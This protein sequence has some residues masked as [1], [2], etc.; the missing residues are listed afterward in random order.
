LCEQYTLILYFALHIFFNETC[1]KMTKTTS[2]IEKKEVIKNKAKQKIII[3]TTEKKTTQKKIVDNNLADTGMKTKKKNE[4]KIGEKADAIVKKVR[5]EVSTEKIE[6]KTVET[7]KITFQLNYQTTYGQELFVIGN[8]NL[9][10]D[11]EVQKALPLQF[12]NNE[13]WFAS[14][15]LPRDNNRIITYNYLLKNTDGTIQF[16]CGNDKQIDTEKLKE[17]EI[18]LIDAWNFTGYTQ[19]TFFTEPFKNILLKQPKSTVK[20]ASNKKITHIFSTKMPLLDSSETIAIIGSGKALGNWQNDKALPMQYDSSTGCYTISVDLSKEDFPIAYKY[21]LCNIESNS[22]LTFEQG[23]NRML[24]DVVQTNKLTKVSD[25][26]VNLPLKNWRGAG[27][28]I[29]VFGLKTNESCGIGEFSDLIAL[30]NWS[31]SVGLKLIQIL[32]INDTTANHTWED[33]Y[34]YAAISAFAL[35][36]IYT[37][38]TKATHPSNKYLL[39]KLENKRIELNAKEA[40]D[41]ESVLKIKTT[42]LKT[43]YRLQASDTFNLPEYKSFFDNNQHW[44]VPYACFCYLRDEYKTPNYN[45]WPAYRHFSEKDIQELSNKNSTAYNDIAFNYFVQYH[46]HIQLLEA[47]NY[48]HK[49]GIILKGDIPIGIFRNGADAWQEPNLY[50]MNVQAGAPPDDFAVKGQNWGFP[51]Y[52]WQ[53]MKEDGFAWWRKR[54]EQM[55]HYFDAFRIDHILGFF[56]IW[57]I[58]MHA[59]EGI[60]GYFVPAIPV[61]TS[62]FFEKGIQFNQ[63]RLTKPFINDQVLWDIF[64]YDNVYVKE[65]FVEKD[66]YGNYSLKQEFATQR[67][68]EKYFHLLDNSD[69]NSKIRQGLYDLIS[70][71]ILFEIDGTNGQQ[72]HFRFNIESTLS[73]KY[74]DNFTQQKLKELYVNYFFER[75]DSFWMKEALQKLPQ[76]RRVTNMLICGEDLGLVP[77]CV[78]DVMQQLGFLSLEIQRMPKDS[79]REFFHPA[80]APFLSVV[81]PS[82]HDMSIIRGWWEEDRAKTQQFFNKELGQWGNAP[83]FCEGWINKAIVVQHLFSPA[84]WAIFQ[85]QDLL[86]MDETL[87]RE[88]PNDERINV[89]A[90]PKHFWQY[91]MNLS[92]EELQQKAE[93][94]SALKSTIAMSGR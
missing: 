21:T 12:F 52:N 43:I 51:T 15:E 83:F 84:M 46:L 80:D 86:G 5:K 79:T 9:I 13:F 47:T 70:N 3:P 53:I 50:N 37:N 31:K 67:Q 78:P 25:A 45:E 87:R 55:S 10:G 33:S 14:I 16:D 39:E 61:Y 62:E 48:A 72:S 81:T 54:F 74:L 30:T 17:N 91:R 18:L 2:S 66:E 35:H 40:V 73:F 64:G 71:V 92:I 20:K 6:K 29:P 24:Y 90:N 77:A 65:N 34:P 4:K 38:L 7:I 57:S 93:F 23:N 68:V 82:T 1:I 42:H 41:Y 22:I 26:F 28:A 69:F 85:L 94:N 59:V 8:H 60:L 89:P 19:N 56:R 36:P 32:P 76:L 88:N 27:I 75:Q 49:N 44:L 11:N 58:P 63:Q